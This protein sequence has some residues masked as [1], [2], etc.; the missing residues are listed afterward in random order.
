[1]FYERTGVGPDGSKRKR[2]Y[3]HESTCIACGL[4]IAALHRAGLATLTHTS[5]PMAFLNEILRRPRN[6]MPYL[7]LVVG[8]P[9]EDCRVPAIE[10]FPLDEVVS[11]R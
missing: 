7:L 3:P 11:F 5:S 9:A 4:L 6:E 8:H 2:Y 10:R 1:M